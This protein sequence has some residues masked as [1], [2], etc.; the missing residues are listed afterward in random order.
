MN[1]PA[2]EQPNP[3]SIARPASHKS[4]GR[5]PKYSPFELTTGT[6]RYPVETSAERTNQTTYGPQS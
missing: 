1:E 3:D 2:E 4:G 6:T 5:Q